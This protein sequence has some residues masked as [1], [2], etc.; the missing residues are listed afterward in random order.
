MKIKAQIVNVENI[1]GTSKANGKPFNFHVAKFIDT[2]AKTSDLLSAVIPD[3]LIV[4]VSALKGKIH[5]I[6]CS[7][8][9]PRLQLDA[10]AS[11]A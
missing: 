9:G 1:S 11:A 2:E 5:M 3:S 4:E 7:L 8:V 10:V 6:A